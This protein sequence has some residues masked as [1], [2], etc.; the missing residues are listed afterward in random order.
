[1]N[2][3]VEILEQLVASTPAPIWRGQPHFPFRE[4]TEPKGTLFDLIL[5][6]QT[7]QGAIGMIWIAFENCD[8]LLCFPVRLSRFQLDGDI[9]SILPWSYRDATTDP[10][11]FEKWKESVRQTPTLVTHRQHYLKYKSFR[12]RKSGVALG[13][14]MCPESSMVRVE[15][16]SNYKF[17]RVLKLPPQSQV[18]YSMLRFLTEKSSFSGFAALGDALEYTL[19]SGQST[20]VAI[21]TQYV[22]Y[23]MTLWIRILNLFNA[24]NHPN[25]SSLAREKT[26]NE[27]QNLVQ[28]SARILGHFHREMTHPKEESL[29]APE[30][31][32][33]PLKREWMDRTKK[34]AFQ[35]VYLLGFHVETVPELSHLMGSVEDLLNEIFTRLS[36][37][38]DLGLVIRLHGKLHL[39]QMLIRKNK[40]FL[41][42]FFSGS[43]NPGSTFF[44][45]KQP[46][47]LDVSS[48]LLSYRFAWFLSKGKQIPFGWKSGND[49]EEHLVMFNRYFVD[50]GKA[51]SSLDAMAL[52]WNAWEALFLK[53]Y[54]NVIMEDA[55]GAELLPVAN[56]IRGQLWNLCQMIHMMSE[57]KNDL[58]SQ[59]PRYQLTIW[60]LNEL[61][62]QNLGGTA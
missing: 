29:I 60:L 2:A 57:L 28:M 16:H 47:Y 52:E 24:L 51:N 38:L 27:I 44:E 8:R 4:L 62:R 17:Y 7:A 48:L 15:M 43:Q 39:G 59:N 26:Q 11:F 5:L 55:Q 20:P 35:L 10:E 61:V 21:G 19:A 58:V 23:D 3:F 50:V 56:E 42:G 34:H 40:L 31:N 13:L 1:M 49:V 14:A 9:F 33:F 18:E 54:H 53:T 25:L 36:Q 46:A 6:H 41:S 30:R 32:A 45:M 37:E 22:Q 12:G